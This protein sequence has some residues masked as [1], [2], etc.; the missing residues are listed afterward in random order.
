MQISRH[1]STLEADELS[2][3]THDTADA[4]HTINMLV[5]AGTDCYGNVLY[6]GRSSDF[7]ASSGH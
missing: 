1:F 7:F 2:G 5:Y 3:L 6:E 4:T